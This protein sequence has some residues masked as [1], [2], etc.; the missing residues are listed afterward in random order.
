MQIFV[1]HSSTWKQ[2]EITI[3]GTNSSGAVYNAYAQLSSFPNPE[4]TVIIIDAV[5]VSY[6]VVAEWLSLC[7]QSLQFAAQIYSEPNTIF[8]FPLTHFHKMMSSS[9]I[10]IHCRTTN[11]YTKC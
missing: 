9:N 1:E 2:N 10:K 6:V 5:P 4:V 11:I 7:P 3:S 8:Y